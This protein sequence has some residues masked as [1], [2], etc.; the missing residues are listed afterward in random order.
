MAKNQVLSWV[1][2]SGW[3]VLSGGPVSLGDVRAAALTRIAVEG[4][5]AYIGINEHDNEELIDD[6]GELGAPTGY[7]VNVMAEDDDTVRQQLTNAALVVVPGN[8]DLATL[9]GGLLGAA[10]EGI[11][12]AFKRGAVI[13]VEG[14]ATMLFGKVVQTD[15]GNLLEGLDWVRNALII[16]AITSI[17]ESPQARDLLASKQA[18]I[19]I[20]IG[21]GS[22]LVLGP[23]AT[24]ELWGQK[25]V[26]LALGAAPPNA[27]T[28]STS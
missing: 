5:V 23:D 15:S 16:P 10:I 20:G 7:L 14:S 13:L 17:S 22:A 12:A 9:R 26:T 28:N 8:F 18:G 11:E 3:L 2:G 1:D 6:M 27:E 24:I 19:A 21:V 4:G 25:Q